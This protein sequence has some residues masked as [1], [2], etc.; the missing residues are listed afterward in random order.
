MRIYSVYS[1]VATGASALLSLQ[2]TCGLELKILAEKPVEPPAKRVRSVEPPVEEEKIV[3]SESVINSDTP[4]APSASVAPI[5]EY[6]GEEGA[7]QVYVSFV[8]IDLITRSIPLSICANNS[9]SSSNN[10]S[11]NSEYFSTF[12]WGDAP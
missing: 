3:P 12:K 8:G 2:N 1:M 6:K 5:S 7:L 9:S 10:D 4:D 11:T